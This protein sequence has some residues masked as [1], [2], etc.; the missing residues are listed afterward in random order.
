MK[1][2]SGGPPRTAERLL[3]R[4]GRRGPTGLSVLGDLREE[5]DEVRSRRGG[6]VAALW[7]WLQAVR[8]AVRLAFERRRRRPAAPLT[9]G[10][11]PSVP[12]TRAGS[13]GPRPPHR[14]PFHL[15]GSP[16]RE[17]AGAAR[18]LMRSPGYAAFTA[19]V[20]ALGIAANTTVFS[21]VNWVMLRPVPG[22]EA[23][24]ELAT[25]R[26]MSDDGATYTVPHAL[27]REL[28]GRS[29]TLAELAAF[30]P[31]AVHLTAGE[32]EPRRIDAQ[33]VTANFFD[34]LRLRMAAGRGFTA[35]EGTD[36]DQADVLVL[37]DRLARELFGGAGVALGATV[38]LSGNPFVVVGV[39]A[40]GFLGP[41][42]PGDRDLWL[43]ASSY[44][45]A[46]PHYREGFLADRRMAA[47][48][49]MVG[50]RAAG[51]TLAQAT[52][53][54]RVLAGA[55][56]EEFGEDAWFR[57]FG[58]V[59]TPGIGVSPELRERMGRSFALMMAAVGFLLLLTCVDVAHLTIA[60]STRRRRELAVRRA[61]GASRGR[62][63]RAILVESVLLALAGGLIAFLVSFGLVRLFRGSRV[64]SWLPEM[65]DVALDARVLAFALAV[66]ALSGLA[67]GLV[68]AL[69]AS[70]GD[71]TTALRHT[72][73]RRA[74]RL[75]DGLVVAQLALSLPLF[76]GAGLLSR[77]VANLRANETGFEPRGVMSLSLEP[78]VQGYGDERTHELYGEI[79]DR[80]GALREVDSVGIVY[81]PP[82]GG[83]RAG[84]L[85]ARVGQDLREAGIFVDHAQVSAG[86]FEA[87]RIPVEGPG[88]DPQRVVVDDDNRRQIVLSRSLARELFGEQPAVGQQVAISVGGGG[89]AAHEVVGVAGDARLFRLGDE[90]RMVVYHPVGQPYLPVETAIVMRGRGDPQAM[91]EGTRRVLRELAPALPV[92]DVASMTQRMDRTIAGERLLARLGAAMALLASL[93]AAVG[94][95]GVV[96]TMVRSRTRE[97]GVRLALG[98]QPAKILARILARTAMVSGLGAAIGVVGAAWMTRWLE[99]T[100]YG[101]ARLDP[102]TFIAAAS[103]ALVIAVVAGLLPALRAARIDPVRTLSAE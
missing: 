57:D 38:L 35:A 37:S 54:M 32:G 19:G 89:A 55:V 23:P 17:L 88:F 98:A 41:E 93:L 3:R 97:L 77:T 58:A 102:V 27:W 51:A 46:M 29:E 96:S 87:L 59:L 26:F 43:P 7:F 53:E 63:V 90:P 101:V 94:I 10:P 21:L 70:A 103:G 61:L 25:L 66:A 82:F 36:P 71:A 99:G 39:A 65:G 91:M 6:S 49:R 52:A 100:L 48:Y 2:A 5:F 44:R 40:P 11:V 95:F 79:V 75:F 74:G 15:I 42:L 56:A 50:R 81:P 22:V 16:A 14:G 24:E 80:V 30:T 69:R 18:G 84:S 72:P 60:R 33:L 85:V 92:F 1:G 86:F 9:S 73:D 34:A 8:I 4:M 83:I 12:G 76:I 47:W 28:S 13:A 45:Q 62:V 68:P 64:I 78:S 20:L 67:F 31:V